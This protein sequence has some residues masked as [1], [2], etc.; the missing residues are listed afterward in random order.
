MLERKSIFHSTVLGKHGKTKPL[1]Q[2]LIWL[3]KVIDATDYPTEKTPV[4][5]FGCGISDIGGF[6]HRV[7]S[8]N[9]FPSGYHTVRGE[10]VL[11][12]VCLNTQQGSS[13][14]TKKWY[15]FQSCTPIFQGKASLMGTLCKVAVHL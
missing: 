12:F 8:Y 11:Q 15:S 7:G 5:R 1:P 2:K 4:Q 13:W 14:K 6:F 3:E 10:S 9:C